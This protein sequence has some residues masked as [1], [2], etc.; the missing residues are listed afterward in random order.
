MKPTT[1]TI[2]GHFEASEL[3]AMIGFIRK[4]NDNNP[5][6]HWEIVADAPHVTMAEAERMLRLM[7]PHVEV[8]RKQ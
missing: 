5:E 6:R 7:F 3:A 8:H 4:L 2:K 1:I